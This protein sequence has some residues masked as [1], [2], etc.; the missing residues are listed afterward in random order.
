MII[1]QTTGNHRSNPLRTGEGQVGVLVGCLRG[2]WDEGGEC[3]GS[4][5]RAES[6]AYLR[7]LGLL[8]RLVSAIAP[9]SAWPE[10]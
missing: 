6:P 3:E 9:S 5:I 10:E 1:L 7:C 4:G 8:F 2:G